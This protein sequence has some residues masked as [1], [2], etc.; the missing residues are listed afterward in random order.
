MNGV[1][2][3]VMWSELRPVPSARVRDD[4]AGIVAEEEADVRC[5][6][7]GLGSRTDPRGERTERE[8]ESERGSRRPLPAFRAVS[9][10]SPR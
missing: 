10:T 2:G 4:G 8:A 3:G 1:R 6:V 7:G 9:P 5:H